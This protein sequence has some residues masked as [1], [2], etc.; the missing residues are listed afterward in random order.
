MQTYS[1]RQAAKKLGL[2]TGTLARYVA[3]GK[4]PAPTVLKVGTA[5]LHAWTDEDIENA[6]KL[7][8]KIVNG[9]KTRY[10]KL[11]E[12]QKRQPGAAVPHKSRRPKKK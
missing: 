5:S 11:R 4:L 6:R 8:P 10:Q 9:R 1:T 7:L 2:H 3:I 12:K